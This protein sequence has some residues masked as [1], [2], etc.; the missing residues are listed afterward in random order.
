M[1]KAEDIKLVGPCGIYCGQCEAYMAGDNA[2]I[3][4]YLLS[5]G[6]KKESL[7]C[8][9]CRELKG[10]CPAL[11]ET[12]ATYTCA[13]QHGVDL[14]YQCPDFPCDKL[15]PASDRANVLPHNLK[16]FNLSC[17]QHQGLDKWLERMP[18]IKQRYYKGKMI[19]GKG[20]QLE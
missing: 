5:K 20:P 12:C 1:I 13:A 2:A 6:F 4:E 17:I 8:P 19:I 7:P 3:M 11:K 14:C 15:N 9:G 16:V 10:N 18:G